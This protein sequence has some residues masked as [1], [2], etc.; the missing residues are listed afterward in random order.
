MSLEFLAL[1][2]FQIYQLLHCFEK[3]ILPKETH[4]SFTSSHLK[5]CYTSYVNTD[6]RNNPDKLLTLM[7]NDNIDSWMSGLVCGAN[8]NCIKEF[9]FILSTA[10]AATKDSSTIFTKLPVD[11]KN[12]LPDCG[13]DNPWQFLS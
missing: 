13:C 12:C 1:K 10:A 5:K 7:R 2:V 9:D 4:F 8:E 6:G 11:G 3:L